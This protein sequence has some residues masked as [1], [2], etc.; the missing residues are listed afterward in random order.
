MSCSYVKRDSIAQGNSRRLEEVS[1]RRRDV[2]RAAGDYAASAP[3]TRSKKEQRNMLI[4]S[5]R[6]SMGRSACSPRKERIFRRQQR[7]ISAS[8]LTYRLRDTAS[9]A[10]FGIVPEIQLPQLG[11]G[12][13]SND[14]LLFQSGLRDRILEF[15]RIEPVGRNAF[16]IKIK[17]AVREGNDEVVIPLI[18]GED[19]MD[20]FRAGL[21]LEL[22]TKLENGSVVTWK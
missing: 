17:K 11:A 15:I 7:N 4:V 1:E 2:V 13:A 20:P 14:P 3:H 5:I 19:D 9:K 16:D 10:V 8:I 21:H 22:K 18:G 12:V 6:A